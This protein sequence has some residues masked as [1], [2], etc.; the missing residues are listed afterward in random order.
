[1]C[2][3]A[4]RAGAARPPGLGPRRPPTA[5]TSTSRLRRPS[6]A[7]R[8]LCAT[9]SPA[10]SF[11]AAVAWRARARLLARTSASFRLRSASH[12]RRHGRRPL[13]LSCAIGPPS[14]RR[15]SFRRGGPSAPR[16][17]RP[18]APRWPSPARRGRV[19]RWPRHLPVAPRRLPASRRGQPPADP[20]WP[21]ASRRMPLLARL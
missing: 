1:M 8:H 18:A 6:C 17:P 16:R 14:L 19:S 20:R 12:A 9:T 15:N 11:S 7:A 2:R 3:G 10:A 5:A 4:S 21:A 13:F